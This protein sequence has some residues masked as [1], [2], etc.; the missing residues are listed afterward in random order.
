MGLLLSSLCVDH[1]MLSY[2]LALA[3]RSDDHKLCPLGFKLSLEMNKK[4]KYVVVV[5]AYRAVLPR[6]LGNNNL[7]LVLFQILI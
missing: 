7:K 1:N 2:Y 6:A 5:I 4:R 3:A